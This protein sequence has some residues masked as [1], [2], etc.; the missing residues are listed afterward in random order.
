MSIIISFFAVFLSAGLLALGIPNEWL[1]SGSAFLGG[2]SLIPL[3]TA[4]CSVPSRRRAACMYGG[5]ISLVHLFSSFWLINFQAF[6]V[7]TL[8][9]STVA[10][11]FLGLP[12]G[13]CIYYCMKLPVRLRPFVFAALW[14]VWEWFKASGFFAYPWGSLAMTGLS[15]RPLIQIAD[16]TGVW[17]ITFLIALTAA[18]LGESLLAA[19]GL[20][21]G[22]SKAQGYP[23]KAPL[24]FT[25]ALLFT[26]HVYGFFRLYEKRTPEKTVRLA[27]IQQNTD[28][29]ILDADVFFENLSGIQKLTENVV[30]ASPEKPDL[31]IW[32]EASLAFGYD[33]F[34][35]YY[36]QLPADESF[37]AFLQRMDIPLLAGSSLLNHAGENA[38][39]NAVFL[40]NPDGSVSDTYSKIKLICFAE[41]IPFIDIPIV[42]KVFTALVGLD[43]SGWAPGTEYKTMRLTVKDGTD[44]NFAAPIC[45]EDAFPAHC[46]QL[47]NRKSDLLLNLTNDSWSKTASAEYQ[48]FAVAYFRALELRTPL[49]RSTNGGYTA[50]IDPIGDVLADLPLFTACGTVVTVPIYPYKR[51]LYAQWQDWLPFLCL[52]ICITAAVLYRLNPSFCPATTVYNS[53][54]FRRL[55][56]FERNLL[57]RKHRW[58]K[59]W[60][61]KNAGNERRR[62][63]GC[64]FL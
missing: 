59:Q 52:M 22:F 19:T 17:G 53:N 25:A 1:H 37:S 10:Y 62:H 26:A 51:T 27:L 32:S 14:T 41:Y 54:S 48:H 16:I 20:T 2:I 13:I 5:F 50:V 38:Y 24:V 31:I 6:A 36:R 35:D 45:F 21:E 12:F 29:W 3:Y 23:L 60:F 11:F 47:H 9:G 61:R 43:S 42:Q 39:S 30:G 64:P 44:I 15:L 18:L 49:V 58:K 46:A 33:Q 7:F 4:F 40:I 28:P 57:Q 8:G 56:A 55:A 34:R 63:S